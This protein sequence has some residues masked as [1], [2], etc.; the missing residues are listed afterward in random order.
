[1]SNTLYIN[2]KW[3]SPVEGHTWNVNSP[4]DG[5]LVATVAEA[6][7]ADVDLAI[8]FYEANNK[9]NESREFI[10]ENLWKIYNKIK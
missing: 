9:I 3:T 8:I 4:A 7:N 6:T 5:H 10:I 2:G 1:M